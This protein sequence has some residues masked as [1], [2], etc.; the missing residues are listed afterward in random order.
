[1]IPCSQAE[2]QNRE[3]F[4]KVKKKFEGTWYCKKENSYLQFFFED[5]THLP[6]VTVNQWIGPWRQNSSIDAFKVFIKND[7]LV[8]PEDRKE[9]LHSYCDMQIVNNKLIF[10]CKGFLTDKDQFQAPSYYVRARK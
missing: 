6:Y 1:M 9:H 2:A 10:R 8:F 5:D 3:E 4:E 7:R